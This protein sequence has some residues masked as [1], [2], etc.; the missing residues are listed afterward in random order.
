MSAQ[1]LPRDAPVQLREDLADPGLYINREL[2]WLDFNERVLEL[3]EDRS[4]PLLERVKFSA[5]YDSN[6]SEFFMVRVAGVQDQIEAGV[7]G[8]QADGMT[9]VETMEAIAARVREFGLRQSRHFEDELR[10]A[11]DSSVADLASLTGE[12]WGGMLVSGAFLGDFVPDGLPWVH[13]DI[14]GPA[15]AGADDGYLVKGGTGF[16]VRTLVE[17]VDRFKKPARSRTAH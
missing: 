10:P 17:L 13:L 6:L 1:P 9:A 7:S 15:R 3:A 4:L 5:I 2:S 14:A 16:A 8:R 11:L 12:R